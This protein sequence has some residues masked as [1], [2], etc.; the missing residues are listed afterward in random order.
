M[1]PAGN[2]YAVSTWAIEPSSV[3]FGQ[4]GFGPCAHLYRLD[5][6]TGAVLQHIG[7]LEAAFVS[8]IDFT[9][10]F[11]LYGSRFVDTQP[12]E[13]GG[14][15]TIHPVTASITVPPNI[16]FG[17]LEN[18]GLA[19]HPLTGDLW[20]IENQGAVGPGTPSI[21]KVDPSTGL[22]ILPVVPLGFGG[23]PVTFGFDALEILPDGRFIATITGSFGLN[24]IYEINP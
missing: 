10:S 20:G 9:E 16:R 15:V 13:D 21:F 3:C 19:V 11:I 4:F 8:D 7:D 5:P 22:A 18:G 2:L 12:Q 17:S 23:Q 1:D 6:T 24:E 14:L